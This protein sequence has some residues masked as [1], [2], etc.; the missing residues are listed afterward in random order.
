V[1]VLILHPQEDSVIDVD[2]IQS[3][4]HRHLAQCQVPIPAASNS[5]SDRMSDTT[6]YIKIAHRG[7]VSD[8]TLKVHCVYWWLVLE[9]IRDPV[10][11]ERGSAKCCLK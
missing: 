4:A 11:H 1:L 10:E 8:L 9:C 6:Y 5:V 7:F 2:F 3:H